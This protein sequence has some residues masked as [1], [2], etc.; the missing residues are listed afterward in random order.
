MKQEKKLLNVGDTVY[1]YAALGNLV[2]IKI[3]RTTSKMAFATSANGVEHKW[4]RAL[5]N[6]DCE[7]TPCVCLGEGHTPTC[8]TATPELEEK[9]LRQQIAKR[10]DTALRLLAPLNH[11]TTHQLN[12]LAHFLEMVKNPTHGL[13]WTPASEPPTHENLIETVQ[14][15]GEEWSISAY[16][17]EER[18]YRDESGYHIYPHFW[19]EI[20]PICLPEIA[21]TCK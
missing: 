5:V 2:K 3:D 15:D 19:R 20:Q 18:V 12:Q 14:A 21:D 13:F 16:D 6:F 7:N 11:L 8:Y 10:C 1:F 9:Y 4:K 17:E